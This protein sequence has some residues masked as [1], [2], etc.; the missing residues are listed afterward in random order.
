MD[1]QMPE[2]IYNSSVPI[3]GIA[4][5]TY[6]KQWTIQTGRSEQPLPHDD[7]EKTRKLPH[8]LKNIDVSNRILEMHFAE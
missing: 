2:P 3:Q 4:L 6:W 1:E 5:K 7:V 8:E